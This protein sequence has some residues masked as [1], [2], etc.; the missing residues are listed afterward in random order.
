[1]RKF[2]KHTLQN[3]DAPLSL[4]HHDCNDTQFTETDPLLMQ[5]RER[6]GRYIEIDLRAYRDG[7]AE[8][9]LVGFPQ[10]VAEVLPVV[11]SFLSTPR[12]KA[13]IDSYLQK[14]LG[15]MVKWLSHLYRETGEA[16]T[17]VFMFTNADGELLKQYLISQPGNLRARGKSLSTVHSFIT[18]AR[19]TGASSLQWPTIEHGRTIKI[20]EDVNPE[21]VRAIY[22]ACKRIL[23]QADQSHRRGLAWLSNGVDPRIQSGPRQI[24]EKGSRGS[25]K[26]QTWYSHA[27][28]A[29]L[30]REYVREKVL[31]SDKFSSQDLTKMRNHLS[32]G[33]T[34]AGVTYT[35]LQHAIAPSNLEVAA[36]ILIVSMETGWI[37]TVDAVDLSTDWFEVRQADNGSEARKTDSVILKAIRPKTGKPHISVGLAGPRFRSFRIIRML[38]KRSE[39]LRTLLREKRKVIEKEPDGL[40]KAAA[41]AEIDYRLRSPWIYLNSRQSGV[42][43]VSRVRLAQLMNEQL[44]IIRKRAL[45]LP[46]VR[47]NANE[48]VAQSIRTLNWSDLRDAFAAHIYAASGGNVFLVKRALNHNDVRVTR[49]YLRQRRLIREHFD[50]FRKVISAALEEVS[51]GR[52][53]DPT[54][55][56][57]RSNYADFTNEDRERLR[58]YRTRLGM[59]CTDPNNPDPVI[60]SRSGALCETQRCILC[61]HGVIFT[62]AW[63]GLADRHADL[64]WIRQASSPIR[65]LTST[66]SWELEAIELARET[67][68]SD[69]KIEF[70]DHS[71][72]RLE[73]LEAGTEFIFDDPSL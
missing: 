59:G 45:E 50:D 40:E 60:S 67:A 54:I 51:Q 37:D 21:A 53:L 44:P 23:E 71:E 62:E 48:K 26:N 38:E 24:W 42:K 30:M 29:V 31:K 36:S 64:I 20:Q 35:D 43:A 73:R 10:I 57:L 6:S 65:W 5:Y 56:F 70:R 28:L 32:R 55:L 63:K 19:G 46:S 15:V 47:K 49:S 7:A 11:R 3:Q 61:R 66:L 34:W 52:A 4:D 17:S 8:R 72:A 25:V 18:R 41:L 68:F 22:N 2:G 33:N 58:L 39:Y 14:S 16:P 12:T 13:S 9:N 1:M 69:V 27:N